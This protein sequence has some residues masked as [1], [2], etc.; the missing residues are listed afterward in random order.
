[1]LRVAPLGGSTTALGKDT[2]NVAPR[3]G[4]DIQF[5]PN[6]VVCGAVGNFFNPLPAFY[7]QASAFT[8]FP[9]SA[10]Q[11]FSQPAAGAPAFTMSV[12]FSANPPCFITQPVTPYTQQ[13]NLAIDHQTMLGLVVWGGYIGQNNRKQNGAS[14]R[15]TM[16]RTS[17]LPIV[18][19][20]ASPCRAPIFPSRFPQSLC[21]L[22][23]SSTA[24]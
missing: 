24:L 8:S 17:T 15:V 7:V 22:T 9:F 11:T 10:A 6:T 12:P 23:P 18:H 4:F 19:V 3:L 1:M 14:G 21:R 16:H 13:Y 5:A 20:L 2:N